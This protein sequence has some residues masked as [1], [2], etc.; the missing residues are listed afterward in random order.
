M[1]R[2]I[3]NLQQHTAG[4][5]GRQQAQLFAAGRQRIHQTDDGN[6]VNSSVF[7]IFFAPH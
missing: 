4:A 1:Q 6:D 2:N 5:S 3:H 7:D